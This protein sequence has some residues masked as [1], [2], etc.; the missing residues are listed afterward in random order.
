MHKSYTIVGNQAI[1]E[2]SWL[3][4]HSTSSSTQYCV[5]P[6]F[7]EQGTAAMAAIVRVSYY[8]SLV[9]HTYFTAL[10]SEVT[11]LI[12]SGNTSVAEGSEV[13]ETAEKQQNYNVLESVL[14]TSRWFRQ[15]CVILET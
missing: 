13:V 6:P 2:G 8:H 3:G 15:P 12:T 1:H 7:P 4:T 10:G 9:A 5:G 14:T 11:A